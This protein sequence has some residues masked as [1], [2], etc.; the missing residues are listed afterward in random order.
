MLVWDG[1]ALGAFFR[2]RAEVIAT[3]R[4]EAIAFLFSPAAIADHAAGRDERQRRADG[5]EGPPRHDNR[6]GNILIAVIK[7]LA[8]H[9]HF[10]F[11]AIEFRAAVG[12]IAQL[13][14]LFRDSLGADCDVR[15]VGHHIVGV[16]I[17]GPPSVGSG[18][19]QVII[20][21][22]SDAAPRG[23]KRNV[24]QARVFAIMT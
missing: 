8:V 20:A 22:H 18:E 12:E 2:R 1:P 19:V 11:F 10:K 4:T 3:V 21:V 14:A 15:I 23:P 9:F 24:N 16:V 5:A 13:P 17:E 7:S 6:S